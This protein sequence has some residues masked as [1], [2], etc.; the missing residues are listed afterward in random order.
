MASGR[1]LPTRLPTSAGRARL[2]MTWQRAPNTKTGNPAPG[3]LTDTAPFMLQPI[4]PP[5]RTSSA[6]DLPPGAV[7]RTRAWRSCC[8]KFSTIHARL[9]LR[10]SSWKPHRETQFT[11]SSKGH[12]SG[13]KG[14]TARQKAKLRR[15]RRF[16]SA[17]LLP[18][19][20]LLSPSRS[21][22][23]V[24]ARPIPFLNTVLK[25]ASSPSTLPPDS[26]HPLHPQLASLH[27]HQAP[28]FPKT[29]NASR[30][31]RAIVTQSR[32]T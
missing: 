21:A 19:P 20:H 6:C 11:V 8:R 18:P 25:L 15:R 27:Q 26:R 29:S 24:T 5:P 10:Q 13:V 2:T 31:P 1:N 30:S 32:T 17:P 28:E 7:C 9:L 4:A 14:P 23:E 22:D 12:S 16:S 3:V